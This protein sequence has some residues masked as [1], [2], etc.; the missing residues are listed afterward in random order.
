MSLT[1]LKLTGRVLVCLVWLIGKVCAQ[2]ILTPIPKPDVS[3]EDNSPFG[4]YEYLP[5]EYQDES[6]TDYP[7]IIYLHGLGDKGNGTT[8]LDSVL[9]SGVAQ[10]LN[11]GNDLSFLVMSPQSNIGW[12]DDD[13]VNAFLDF[14]LGN[15]RVDSR[16]VYITGISAGGI[17]VFS[18]AAAYPN[19]LAAIV[20]ITGKANNIDVCDLRE[21]PTWAFHNEDDPTFNPKFSIES[22]AELNECQPT[23]SPLAKVTIY[24]S[25]GH[26]AWTKTYDGTGMGTEDPSY[27][28]FNVD[29]F[30]WM[31]Q[32]AKDTLIAEFDNDQILFPPEN[33]ILLENYAAS[34]DG[35]H[36]YSWTQLSGPDL[37]VEEQMEGNLNYQNV[38]TGNYRFSLTITDDFGHQASDTITVNVRPPNTPPLVNAGTDKAL[39]LPLDSVTFSGMVSDPEQDSTVFAWL[40]ITDTSTIVLQENNEQLI[41]RDLSIGTYTFQLSATDEYDSTSQ[42][43]VQLLV[44]NP[45]TQ[46]ISDFP[47]QNSFEEINEESW[48]GYG[49]NNSWEQGQPA[50]SVVNEASDESQVWATNLTGDYQSKESSFLLSPVFDFSN[51]SNDPTIRYDIWADIAPNDSIY[52]SIT[53][54]QGAT[55]KSFP[56][57]N[58]KSN[59]E[60]T[61]VSHIL[62]GTA[63]KESVIFRI[64]LESNNTEGHEGVAIDNMTVCSAG[65]IT[66]LT[67]TMVVEGESLE[68]PIELDNSD[69]TEVTY[70]A[71]S[72]NQD[73]LPDENMTISEGILKITSLPQTEGETEITISTTDV[74]VNSTTFTLNVARVTALDKPDQLSQVQLYPNPSTGYYQIESEDAIREARIYSPTGQLLER[75]TKSANARREL[76][77]DIY[78]QPNGIY[79]LQVETDRNVLTRK[80]IK[81]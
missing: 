16:R 66:S 76:S 44:I 59:D 67:D 19:R 5:P 6:T 61:S 55:W 28:P 2:G 20:P 48:Q 39:L 25:G 21:V 70:R 40:Q 73:I 81:Y 69:I 36:S 77:F 56:L 31:L 75:Y 15:Y 68:V 71:T 10:F 9:R 78:S 18:Y 17:E 23:P 43:D 11:T 3:Q 52:L 46:V 79:Y 80:V 60:W 45:P 34:P 12:W 24:P 72:S 14:I 1:L 4:Y 32:F 53:S 8:E 30:D 35:Q 65:S 74:C 47:Y 38:P 50:G 64:G 27:D 63:G 7:L 13:G 26:D 29:I 49:S 42:D 37:N 22:V 41:F 58:E 33:D 51:L 62:E 54:D 57:V